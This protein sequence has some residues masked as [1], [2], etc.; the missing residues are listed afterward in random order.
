MDTK[1]TKRGVN[2]EWNQERVKYTEI[3][4]EYQA[5]KVYYTKHLKIMYTDTH[6]KHVA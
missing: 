2:E 1:R 6:K 5:F 3:N 4:A